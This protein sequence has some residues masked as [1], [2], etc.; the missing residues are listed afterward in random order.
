MQKPGEPDK[1]W[2]KRWYEIYDK[3]GWD[4]NT[5][6][7]T[8]EEFIFQKRIHKA[9]SPLMRYVLEVRRRK[10]YLDRMDAAKASH[11]KTKKTKAA[12]NDCEIRA[13]TDKNAKKDRKR[14]KDEAEKAKLK[15]HRAVDEEWSHSSSR[16]EYTFRPSLK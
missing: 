10:S 8:P 5:A 12:K 2:M 4:P 3:L 7:V 13:E 14:E 11:K 16:S 15:A 1:D 9:K 6:L